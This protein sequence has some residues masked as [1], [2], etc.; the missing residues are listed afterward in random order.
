MNIPSKC[1]GCLH[2][3]SNSHNDFKVRWL[4]MFLFSH[5]CEEHFPHHPWLI[6]LVNEIEE[7]LGVTESGVAYNTYLFIAV[8]ILFVPICAFLV[9]IGHI[10]KKTLFLCAVNQKYRPK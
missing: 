4:F 3:A 7:H 6:E 9:C 8:L 10:N 1:K 5:K 2:Y